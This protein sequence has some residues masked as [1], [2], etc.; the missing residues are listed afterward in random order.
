MSGR[1][2]ASTTNQQTTLDTGS[3]ARRFGIVATITGQGDTYNIK[4]ENNSAARTPIGGGLRNCIYT[5]SKDSRRRLLHLF[6]RL[7][8]HRTRTVFLTLTFNHQ[9][10]AKSA[11]NT[12]RA[13]NER[14]RRRF[15]R[16]SHIWRM[17]RQE[18]GDIHFHLILFNF[19]YV[20][21]KDL[22]RWWTQTTGENLSIV[23]VKLLRGKKRAFYYCS[24]YCAK[25]SAGNTYFIP[26][27]YPHAPTWE[28]RFWGIQNRAMLP[29][30]ELK[31]WVID[32]LDA[33]LYIRYWWLKSAKVAY[34]PSRYSNFQC[35]LFGG[36]GHFGM[37]NRSVY[38]LQKQFAN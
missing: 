2:Y 24:K 3:N 34:S 38:P 11:K 28:G 15:P 20:P 12:L 36:V 25:E 30:D 9:Q 10:D 37:A 13:F 7:K 8:T 17:E 23:H 1:T 27:T 16:S 6:G 22:Q 26:A 33:A 21:Q 5:F 31:Q 4:F 19:P 14:I 32:D 18:R 29:Y 35:L